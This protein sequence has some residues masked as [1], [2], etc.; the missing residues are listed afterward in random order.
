MKKIKLKE[1]SVSSF[2][3][4]SENHACKLNGGANRYKPTFGC[5]SNMAN[6]ACNTKYSYV[7]F[8]CP[9]SLIAQQCSDTVAGDT[10]S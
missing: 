1:L 7:V 6:D 2:L 5:P 9:P 10:G 8:T 4:E 3:I